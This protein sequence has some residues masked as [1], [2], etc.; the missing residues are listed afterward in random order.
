MSQP[1][2][3]RPRRLIRAALILGLATASAAAC[4]TAFPALA[5]AK[6]LPTQS[7]GVSWGANAS[8]Q[9]GD[10]SPFSNW[11]YTNISGLAGVRQ[12]SA[13]QNY[14]L[15]AM[16]SGQVY[17]WGDDSSGQLGTAASSTTPA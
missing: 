2:P 8:G 17:A 11:V 16:T 6:T 10:G 15:A 13:G 14:G 9:L 5:Q 1:H 12:I 4:A 3:P 7:Q